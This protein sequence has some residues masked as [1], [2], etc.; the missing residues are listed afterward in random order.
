MNIK[1]PAKNAGFLEY[2]IIRKP[3]SVLAN[4]L[5]SPTVASGIKRF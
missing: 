2:Q 5:S 1:N 4:H 3:G